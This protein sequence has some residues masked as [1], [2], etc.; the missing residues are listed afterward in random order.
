[1]SGHVFLSHSSKDSGTA[2]EALKY[3]EANGVDCWISSRDI[4]PG[5]DWAETIYNAIA[6]S[7][8]MI[9]FFTDN[10]N[11]SWQVRNEL[12]I[13][14]NLRIPIIPVRLDDAEV[15]KGLRYFT[16]SH[17][18]LEKRDKS[19]DALLDGI[20][21]AVLRVRAGDDERSPAVRE[22]WRRRILS[23]WLLAVAAFAIAVPATIFL[24]RMGRPAQA[25]ETAGLLAGGTDSWDFATD[26]CIRSGGG[27]F[28]SGVWDWGFEAEAWVAGF[29][30][31][32]SLSWSWSDSMA[33]ECRPMIVPSGDGGVI[34][35][36]G[37]YADFGHT[38]YSVEAVRLDSLGGQVWRDTVRIE[39][40]GAAQPIFG[41]M[42]KGP[43]GM[44]HLAFTLRTRGNS[45]CDAVHLVTVDPDDGAMA[46]D[47]I[48]GCKESCAYL[49]DS[50]GG[51]FNVF[52]DS[53]TR[54]TGIEH[55]SPAGVLLARIVLG[56]QRMQPG[57]AVLTSDGNLVV[58]VTSDGYGAGNGDLLVMEF[59]PDLTLRW[60]EEFG[61][62]LWDGAG[63][64][65]QLNDGSLALAG[66][67]MSFGDGSSDGWVLFLDGDGELRDQAVI[68]LGG[69]EDIYSIAETERGSLLAAG[70]T[71]ELGQPDAWMTAIRRDGSYPAQ[72]RLGLDLMSEDWQTGF[73]N[74]T[75]WQ[76]GQ[77]RNYSPSILIDSATGN[78]A[79][80]L[81]C[82]PMASRDAFVPAQGLCLSADVLISDMPAAFGSNSVEIGLTSASLEGY[83]RDP[84]DAASATL[85]WTYTAGINGQSRSV[86][87]S[88]TLGDSLFS[89]LEP[90]SA[91]T[92]RGAPQ[93]LMIELCRASVR[94]WIGDSL[95]AEAPVSWGGIDSLRICLNGNSDSSPHKLDDV[96]L[97]MRRW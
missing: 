62:D 58:C 83:D 92:V 14:T 47:T 33:G 63:C 20:L 16:N 25:A 74:Q 55:Y 28:A 60:Q 23:P 6:S 26:I 15:A 53:E 37:Q 4:P 71:T 88:C 1:M 13:A 31:A 68:D 90:D 19:M 80:D 18:W 30:S 54:A 97:F 10:S 50:S 72:Q 51:F 12:D 40:P 3:L 34:A 9:L 79:L 64:A 41:S 87:A 36:Y 96:R 17:Q 44:I 89:T 65:I 29:D 39:W 2:G 42:E 70:T 69:D 93:R 77:N 38:G 27:F 48:P 76:M 73:V 95:L 75:V 86:Q 78:V 43:D 32:G 57:T 11:D 5:S 46:W 49:P 91:W 56:D 66:S 82:V 52:R 61:G 94:Y 84:A 67:T 8:A 24:S 21:G 7:S 81:N 35:A 22:A 59:T 85:R 45:P